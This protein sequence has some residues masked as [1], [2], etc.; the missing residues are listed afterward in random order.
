MMFMS[1]L[2]PSSFRSKVRFYTDLA[3][4]QPVFN[5]LASAMR[6]TV[7]SILM[8]IID[9]HV[10]VA[11]IFNNGWRTACLGTQRLESHFDQTSFQSF[12]CIDSLLRQKSYSLYN[13]S[14]NIRVE[15][16]TYQFSECSCTLSRQVVDNAIALP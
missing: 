13:S 14:V 11:E 6:I 4:I 12:Y 8:N 7:I 1:G 9:I 15:L 2:E 3:I 16:N 10:A 5:I